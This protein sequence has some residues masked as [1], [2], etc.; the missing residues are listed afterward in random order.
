[1]RPL[2]WWPKMRSA[3]ESCMDDSLVVLPN[4]STFVESLMSK[5]TFSFPAEHRALV[6]RPC[7]GF[8]FEIG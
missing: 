1:M 2:P 8:G 3:R 5:A 7:E 4:E 6:P